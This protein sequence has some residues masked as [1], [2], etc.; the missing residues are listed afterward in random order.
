MRPAPRRGGKLVAAHSLS[1]VVAKS[2]T[3]ISGPC[4]Q[5]TVLRLFPAQCASLRV[6][7]SVSEEWQGHVK[8]ALEGLRVTALTPNKTGCPHQ[9]LARLPTIH[10]PKKAEAGAPPA[11]QHSLHLLWLKYQPC[12][13]A[14]AS[15]PCSRFLAWD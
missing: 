13:P 7:P 11:A 5:H 15:R 4:V 10:Q 12:L 14:R 8:D 3:S 1:S 9:L 6:N 2:R